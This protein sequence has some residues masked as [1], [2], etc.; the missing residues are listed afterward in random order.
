MKWRSRYSVLCKIVKR[1]FSPADE[2]HHSFAMQPRKT[3]NLHQHFILDLIAFSFW[4]NFFLMKHHDAA[5]LCALR[6]HCGLLIKR[7]QFHSCMILLVWYLLTCTFA[8]LS[9]FELKWIYLRNICLNVGYI[10]I[11][12]K[13]YNIFGMVEFFRHSTYIDDDIHDPHKKWFKFWIFFWFKMDWLHPRVY[14]GFVTKQK[15]PIKDFHF[16]QNHEK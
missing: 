7:F 2:A 5:H 13:L 4:F 10:S 11:Y 8:P 16:M 3:R 1:T 14:K 12:R 9:S 15:C 6:D